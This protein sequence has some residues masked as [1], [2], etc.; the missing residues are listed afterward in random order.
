MYEPEKDKPRHTRRLIAVDGGGGAG[1][2]T[3]AKYLQKAIPKSY[4]VK[5]DDFYRPPQLRKP[6]L[7]T[8]VINPNFDWDRLYFSVIEAVQTK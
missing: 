6:L 8:K 4:I 7:S 2:T 3:F 5:V 1:K